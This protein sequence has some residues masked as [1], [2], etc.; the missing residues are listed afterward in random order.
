MFLLMNLAEQN[1][2]MIGGIKNV[3]MKLAKIFT[4]YMYMCSPKR[5]LG[6][7]ICTMP[8]KKKSSYQ[9]ILGKTLKID[10]FTTIFHRV[11]TS[12]LWQQL[13]TSY[14]I[15]NVFDI[16]GNEECVKFVHTCSLK[17]MRTL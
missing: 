5:H 15:T 17:Y 2:C 13:G 7:G 6:L 4:I 10:T 9:N 12:M 14:S 1:I 3:T 11:V 16:Q 8:E